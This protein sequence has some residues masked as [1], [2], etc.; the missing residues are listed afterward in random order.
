TQPGTPSR[1]RSGPPRRRSRG[2]AFAENTLDPVDELDGL[3]AALEHR[4]ERALVALVGCILARRKADVRRDGTQPLAVAVA[5]VRED[6]NRADLVC[7]HHPADANSSARGE[8]TDHADPCSF[9]C[10]SSGPAVLLVDPA[11]AGAGSLRG[12]RSRLAPRLP[13]SAV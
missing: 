8:R 12:T 3:D 7:R 10:S 2:G 13:G 9:T 1:A 6:G 4:V 5:K 11:A